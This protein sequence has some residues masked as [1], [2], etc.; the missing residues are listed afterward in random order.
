MKKNTS[1][2]TPEELEELKKLI[3]SESYMKEAIFALSTSLTK[4]ISKDIEI[5]RSPCIGVD[6]EECCDRAECTRGELYGM[7]NDRRCKKIS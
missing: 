7:Q 2:R 3:H 5:D 4:D 1:K 6:C